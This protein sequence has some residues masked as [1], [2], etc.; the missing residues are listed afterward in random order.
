RQIADLHHIQQIT[1]QNAIVIRDTPDKLAVV[2]KILRD[3]DRARPEVVVQ[4]SV[5][6]AQSDRARQLG[7]T[8]GSSVVLAF[9][10]NNGTG[11]STNSTSGTTSSSSI[12]SL[13]LQQ[14]GHLSSA[15][16]SVTLPGATAM[17]LLTDTT[18][19]II[20]NPEI[21]MVDGQSAKLKIGDRI[22]VATGSFQAGLGATSTAGVINPL[23]NTQFQYL[24]VGVNIDITPRIHLN[25][26][27]SLKVVVDVSSVTGQVNLGGINQPIIGQRKIEHD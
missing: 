15:D 16:Y 2:E 10:P 21:R 27:V 26:E 8:P 3:V 14:L 13:T 24:D 12:P 19:K 9:T 11:T 7:I 6:Q 5:L 17:A 23:V 4:V 1:S 25:R 20:D 22:P 18:T